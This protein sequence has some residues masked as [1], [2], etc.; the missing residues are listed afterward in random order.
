MPIAV[1]IGLVR[2]A[3]QVVRRAVYG[4][5]GF[6]SGRRERRLLA[7]EEERR[8]LW[9][10]LHD[11]V[12]PTL[13]GMGRQVRAARRL[14]LDGGPMAN[15]LDQLDADLVSCSRDIGRLVNQLEPDRRS[16]RTP[17]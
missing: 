13:A 2:L 17:R 6:D 1:H 9:G 14:V 12:G 3:D 5:R 4:R 8:R 10:D 15:L 16:P 7:W 11:G